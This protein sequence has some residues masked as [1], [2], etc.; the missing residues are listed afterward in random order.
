MVALAVPNEEALRHIAEALGKQSQT[1]KLI[2]EDAGRFA[3]QVMALGV[4]PVDDRSELKRVVSALP[5]IK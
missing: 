1:Y 3:G 5:L 4:T 2:T